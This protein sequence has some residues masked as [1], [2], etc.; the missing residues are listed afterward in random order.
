[1]ALSEKKRISNDRW[2]KENYRQVKLSM[3]KAEAEELDAYCSSRNLS[4]AGFIRAAIKEKMVRDEISVDN[5]DDGSDA[6]KCA[7]NKPSEVTE[8]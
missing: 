5:T 2:I 6:S 3:P 1:M 7:H 8:E 4:K